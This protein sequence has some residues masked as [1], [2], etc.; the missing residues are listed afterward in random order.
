MTVLLGTDWHRN[1]D[2]LKKPDYFVKV[3]VLLHLAVLRGYREMWNNNLIMTFLNPEWCITY[4]LMVSP[5]LEMALMR[6]MVYQEH[7]V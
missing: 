4:N 2:A 5:F 6:K 1:Y 7:R 3:T